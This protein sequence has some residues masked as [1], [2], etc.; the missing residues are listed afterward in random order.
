M[1][2]K[3]DM[4]ILSILQDSGRTSNADIARAVGMAPSAVLERMR[5][6]ERKGIIRGFEAVLRPKDVGFTLTAFTFVRADEGVGSTDIGKALAQ[7]PGVLE[8]HYTAGQ[9][10]YLV[11]VRARD[12]EHLQHILQQFGAIPGVRDT[13]TTVVLTTL[14]ETRSLPILEDAQASGNDTATS[15]AK[16]QTKE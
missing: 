16:A 1:I 2:D 11:K 6:L 13:R 5:K 9:D 8:A 7:V 3:I 4:T 15:G 14:K 12:T 10:S